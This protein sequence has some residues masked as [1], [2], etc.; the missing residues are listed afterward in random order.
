MSSFNRSEDV[1]NSNQQTAQETKIWNGKFDFDASAH[2]GTVMPYHQKL[3]QNSII[4]P[5]TMAR[6]QSMIE[7]RTEG[8]KCTNCDYTTKML[9]HMKEHVEKHIEGLE[10][11][12]NLCHKTFRSSHSFR[13]HSK[14]CVNVWGKKFEFQFFQDKCQPTHPQQDSPFQKLEINS[15]PKYSCCQ[16]F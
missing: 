9:G 8:Y 16:V 10:Y 12:C 3:K 7:K 4:S 13:N 6:I 14:A 11:P 15:Y 5:D 1:A 2:K